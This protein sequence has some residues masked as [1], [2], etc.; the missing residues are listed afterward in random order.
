MS[1]VQENVRGKRH[2]SSYS[3]YLLYRS[4]KFPPG[5]ASHIYSHLTNS[6]FFPAELRS[7]SVHELIP[8]VFRPEALP[9]HFRTLTQALSAS[10]T[11]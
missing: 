2:G 7:L 8:P 10:P 6:K 3:Q 11:H 1:L 4:H 5:A 9:N